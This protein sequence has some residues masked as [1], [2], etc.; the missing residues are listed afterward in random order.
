MAKIL[1]VD[2]EPTLIKV[3]AVYLRKRGHEAVLAL[4]GVYA[5]EKLDG[6]APDLVV[7]DLHMPRMDGH[8]L[9]DAL[10]DRFGAHVPSILMTAF[11]TPELTPELVARGVREVLRKSGFSM[12]EFGAAVDRALSPPAT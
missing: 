1:L 12:S 10:R 3:M 8:Q 2:D 4:D 11:L 5:I 6:A 7:C 9:L